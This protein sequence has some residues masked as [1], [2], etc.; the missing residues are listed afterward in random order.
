MARRRGDGGSRGEGER[1]L[2]AE[3]FAEARA[4]IGVAAPT[5]SSTAVSPGTNAG[6]EDGNPN[7]DGPKPRRRRG[8]QN[9][10]IGRPPGRLYFR[11][12]LETV[13]RCL[14]V[15]V[16]EAREGKLS[17]QQANACINGLNS[18][19]AN[20]RFERQ[21]VRKREDEQMIEQLKGLLEQNG[22]IRAMLVERGIM[23]P[24]DAAPP[25]GVLNG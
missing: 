14:E 7:D 4:K 2:V 11:K 17:P 16:N 24:S 19:A 22:R 1:D 25:V 20:L 10:R 8:G 15:I 18:V 3:S 9:G 21:Q 12:S 13:N 5:S 6:S 23:R